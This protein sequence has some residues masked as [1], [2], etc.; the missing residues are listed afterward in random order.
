MKNQALEKLYEKYHYELY[1]YSLAL[2]KNNHTA[3]ELVSDTFFKAILSL[4]DDNT[5]I[6]YWLFRVCKNIWIDKIRKTRNEGLSYEENVEI[7]VKDDIVDSLIVKEEHEELYKQIMNLPLNYRVVIT[8]YYF[9][10]MPLKIIAQNLNMSPG[11][12]RTLLF[13]ARQKLKNFIEEDLV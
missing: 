6:K 5:E 8:L 12:V 2:C 4:D 10:D 7:V 1:L 13:R 11:S 9:C 3:Q